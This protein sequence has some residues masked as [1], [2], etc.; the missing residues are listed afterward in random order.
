MRI[1]HYFL[2]FPPYRTGGLTKYALDLMKSQ[3]FDGHEVMALWPGEIKNYSGKPRIKRR[4]PIRTIA[5]FEM[6]N[7]LPVPLDEGINEFFAYTRS[8]DIDVFISFLKKESPNV[9]HIHTLMGLYKEFVEAANLL[10]IRTVTTSHDYF[11]LCPKV[12]FYRQG[13]CCDDDENCRKCVQCNMTSL[14]LKK[15]QLMQSPL[16]RRMKDMYVVKKIRQQ[17]RRHFFYGDDLQET[18][19][20]DIPVLA[21]KYQKLRKYYVDIYEKIDF[22]HFNSTLA[23][24]IYKRYVIPKDSAVISITHEGIECHE[25]KRKVE[26]NKKVILYLAPTKPF[27]GWNVI[28]EACDQLWEEGTKIE[29]RVY[30][31]VDKVEPY[32][33]VKEKGFL[34]EELGQIMSEAD[35]LVAPSIWYETFGFTVLEALSYGVPVI[36]SNHVGAKDIVGTSGIVV[37]AGNV[38]ELKY[39]IRQFDARMMSVDATIKNWRQFL[40]ENY[41]IYW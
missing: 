7:P 35:M 16:Y 22:I 32:M 5:N 21:E 31:I 15:I 24:K 9:I 6:I 17:H 18:S 36:V 10:T 3:A 20:I 1:L 11:G 4:E 38:E 12:T 39:A 40:D 34:P 41:S 25:I 23:E 33:V 19:N 29:L 8:C 13:E 2:G 37:E 26:R 27:K 14:S 28:K 30:D